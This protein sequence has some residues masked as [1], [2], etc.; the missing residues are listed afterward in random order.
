MY[1]VQRAGHHAGRDVVVVRED[2]R[3]ISGASL[4]FVNWMRTKVPDR[5]LRPEQQALVRWWTNR[6]QATGELIG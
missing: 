2:G 1:K 3:L 5:Q 6:A 4:E